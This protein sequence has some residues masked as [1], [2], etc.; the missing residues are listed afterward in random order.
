[1]KVVHWRLGDV[2][3]EVRGSA[4]EVVG[5]TRTERLTLSVEIEG[6]GR[7]VSRVAEALRAALEAI[8][9]EAPPHVDL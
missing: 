1:M 8:G 3:Q 7:H 5:H 6:D 9:C 4:G 2:P